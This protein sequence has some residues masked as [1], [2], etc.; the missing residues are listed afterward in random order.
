[1]TAPLMPD[2]NARIRERFAAFGDVQLPI[3]EREAIRPPRRNNSP[4]S[5]R[6][7][8]HSRATCTRS[9]T[10]KSAQSRNPPDC[11]A[12]ARILDQATHNKIVSFI[13]GSADDALRDLYEISFTR[14]FFK[15]QPLRTLSEI[16][17]DVL[18]TEKEAEG[19]LIAGTLP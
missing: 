12:H 7:P 19:L 5:S 14:H 11:L 6:A 10:E 15:P 8:W 17:A 9:S 18:A 4:R 1:V 16:A 13:R 2:L 3:L